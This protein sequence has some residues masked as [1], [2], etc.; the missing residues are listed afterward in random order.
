[1][2]ENCRSVCE[3]P[4]SEN[5]GDHANQRHIKYDERNGAEYDWST[6][7]IISCVH[8][9]ISF[10]MAVD[11]NRGTLLA[12][13]WSGPVCFNSSYFRSSFDFN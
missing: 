11:V 4:F 5:H 8:D 3:L 13:G 7:S 10:G 2:L 6:P 12:D 9:N 1:M